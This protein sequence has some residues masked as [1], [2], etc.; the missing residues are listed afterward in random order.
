METGKISRVLEIYTK[1]VNGKFI[2]K[3]EEANKYEVSERTI[4]RDIDD[5][6]CFFEQQMESTGVINQVVYDRIRDGYH[7]E[8]VYKMKLSNS[9]ILAICK[10]LLDSR[11]FTK[12]EMSQM[13]KKLIDCC[14]PKENQKL[15]TDLISNE[16]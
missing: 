1:L 12:N 8:Q 2:N 9:E 14:V 11:A 5:I 13:L 6:R 15:V 10:I 3:V 7:L 4:Q 16:E